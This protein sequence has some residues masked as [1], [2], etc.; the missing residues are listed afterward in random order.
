MGGRRGWG[1]REEGV[2][3]WEGGGGGRGWEGGGGGGGLEVF[4]KQERLNL[5]TPDGVRLL[6]N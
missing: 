4:G 5:L 6:I 3:G 2:G 1:G